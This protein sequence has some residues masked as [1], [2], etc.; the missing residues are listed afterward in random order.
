MRPKEV[1]GKSDEMQN[2]TDGDDRSNA[3]QDTCRTGHL[4]NMKD[5][6]HAGHMIMQYRTDAGHDGCR[7]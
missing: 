5:A 7:T 3:V 6:G 4:K 1:Q 2:R